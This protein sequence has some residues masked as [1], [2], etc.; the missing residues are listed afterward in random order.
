MVNNGSSVSTDSG[1]RDWPAP[2]AAYVHV[3]FCRHRCGYCNFSVVSGRDDLVDR[4]LAALDQEL[5]PLDRPSIETLFVGGGTPTHLEPPHLAELL[6]LLARRFRLTKDVEWSVEANPEDM[7]PA[8]LGLLAD[9][10]VNRLSLGVQSF[11]D[12]KLAALERNHSG[13][14]AAE[15][16]RRTAEVIANLSLDLIFAAPDETLEVWQSDVETALSLPIR[17]LSTYALTY[18]KGTTFWN[19]RRRGQLQPSPESLEVAMYDLV[20]DRTAAAG[21]QHYEISN[22]AGPGHECRHNTAYWE[23]RGW[24]AAGP[25]AARFVGGVR[26]LNHRSTTTYLRRIEAGVDPTAETE[27]ISRE[28]HARERAAFGIRM[29]R[30]IDVEEISR[31]TG[32]DLDTL[33]GEAIENSVAAGWLERHGSRVKLTHGGVLFA[34]AVAREFL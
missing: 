6:C 31:E 15:V 12:S 21:W 33:C 11:D 8:R 5:A 30:G 26:Q 16:V 18:E 4:F 3:P 24:Y 9:H 25:G 17:H 19:R 34:D 28:D 22:F 29:L 27:V 23:G 2:R 7:D 14:V 13:T 20:R 32:A 10:G 1:F